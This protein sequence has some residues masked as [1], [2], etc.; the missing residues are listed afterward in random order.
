MDDESIIQL[1][2]DRNDQ[3]IR[4]TSEK[5]GHYCKSIARNILDNDEDAE[6]CVN[7]TYLNAWNSMPMHWPKQLSTFLG[8][9][10]RNLSFN[11]YKH[12]RAEKRG[13]GEITLV[14]DELADCVSDTENIEQIIDRRE[15]AKAINS[16]VRGLS[17]GKRNLFIRRYWYADPVLKIAADYGML[18]GSVSKTLE[19]TRKQLK[20]YLTERGF[21]L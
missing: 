19:R 2:W 20:A 12:N 7:D 5:Y 13:S 4:I 11:K 17:T 14:L 10:T 15:L 16:F 1:Y 8:K 18:Q 6:E 3:A 9:I 21:E